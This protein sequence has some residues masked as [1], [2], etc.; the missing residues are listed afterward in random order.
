MT[1]STHGQPVSERLSSLWE[2]PRVIDHIFA[3][4]DH[5]RLGVRYMVTAFVFFLVGGTLA[6]MM[7]T[8]LAVPENQFLGPESYNRIFTMHGTTMIFYFATP[9]LTGIATYILPLMLGT[10]DLAFP[11]L[12][13]FAYWVFLFS[14]LFI[15]T[16]FLVDEVPDGGWFAYVPLT[17]PNYSQ[18]LG[19]DFWTLA[20]LFLGISTTAAAINFVVTILRMRAPGMAVHRMP[21]FLWGVLDMAFTI[22]IAL[23]S[24]T[25]ATLL[26][27]LDRTFGT[28]FY[29]PA[30][31]GNPLLWQ[32][33][34]WIW[35]HPE[36]YILLLPSLGIISTVVTA[37]ARREV[38]MYPLVAVASVAIGILAFG[39][40][41]HH[42]FSTG[43][44]LLPISFFSAASFT[45]AIPSGISI[46]AWVTTIYGGRVRF[47]PAFMFALGFIVTFVIGGVSGVMVAMVPFD[48]QV[49]DS[50]FVVAHFHYVLV[51]GVVFPVFAGLYHWFPKI[52]G[53]MTVPTLGH[54]AFWLI[55]LGFNITFFPQHIL[56]LLGMPRR[57]YTY[58]EGLGWDTYNAISTAGYVV[59]GLGIIVMVFD[60]LWSMQRG[61]E[62]GDDPWEADSLEWATPSPPEPYN[63][64]H[65]PIVHSRTPMWLDRTPERGGQ[66]DRIEDP[67]DDGRE[68]VTTSVLDAAP[69]AV[70][71]VSEPSYVPLFAALA[72]TVAVVAMLVEVYPVSVAGIVGLGALLAVWLWRSP[73]PAPE[74]VNQIRD[75]VHLP[76]VRIAGPH[77]LGRWGMIFFIVTEAVLFGSLISSYFLVRGSADE[78]PLGGIA[79]P[80]LIL[81]AILTA[82]IVLS[83]A[84]MFWAQRQVEGSADR[85]PPLG[86]LRLALVVSLALGIAFL[87]LQAYEFHRS[88][89]GPSTNAYGSLF[90]MITGTHAA[91]MGVGVLLIGWT[92]LRTWFVSH[93]PGQRSD[94]PNVALYWHFV[95]VVWLVI[96]SVV[97]LGVRGL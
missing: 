3:T 37:H 59:L 10:R 15:Y 21:L 26:L 17:G 50:Y 54:G 45:I 42:M 96:L 41:V 79:E 22:L 32:H 73:A 9:M 93:E 74:R 11:R 63:F 1:A 44:D 91:H 81:P 36:V 46:F 35:G 20:I 24:L 2:R 5:K 33:L 89:F 67:M 6:G 64:A 87:S 28:H 90:F 97:Y 34:F 51:G 65:L 13:A 69:D 77:S 60:F 84:S 49:H 52:T 66:L 31:G 94:V 40:W 95:G 53:R 39:L 18:G 92:L 61:E 56:G 88:E 72:L 55:F 4:V 23:P 38:V 76:D 29:D 68:V 16:S 86:M 71:R 58:A 7:R 82:L 19:M 57:V 27:A 25:L 30:G 14:G 47:S 78:W 75:R 48:W 83:S 85:N 12:N 8:Q 80:E 70:L 43:L 62:A